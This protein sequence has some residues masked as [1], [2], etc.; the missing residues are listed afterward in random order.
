M[1]LADRLA[2]NLADYTKAEKE[3]IRDV[4]SKIAKTSRVIKAGFFSED[5]MLPCYLDRDDRVFLHPVN[6]TEIKR[7]PAQPSDR[8]LRLKM[9]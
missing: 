2:S 6:G 9:A 8:Q 3:K 1:I 4:E 5:E 7:V